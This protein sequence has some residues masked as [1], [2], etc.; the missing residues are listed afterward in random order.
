MRIKQS[1][2][3]H[4]FAAKDRVP[5]FDDSVFRG[6]RIC[7]KL[8]YPDAE[9]IMEVSEPPCKSGNSVVSRS[10]ESHR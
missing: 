9:F 1:C 6:I 5:I 8:G 10:E 4:F 7:A 3:Q 2:V